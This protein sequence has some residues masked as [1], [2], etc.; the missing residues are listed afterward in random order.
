MASTK[1]TKTVPH[2]PSI[3]GE[4]L[5]ESVEYM[6]TTGAKMLVYRLA[7]RLVDLCHLNI[8]LIPS[9]FRKESG[10][11][12]AQRENMVWMRYIFRRAKIDSPN[13]YLG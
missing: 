11:R 2:I 1:L 4:A 7:W 5:R 6:R 9:S 12:D 13:P 8:T 3:A 10:I